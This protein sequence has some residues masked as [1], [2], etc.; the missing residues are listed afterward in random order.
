MATTRLYPGGGGAPRILERPD[1]ALDEVLAPTPASE[2]AG[3]PAG[4][5][6]EP[7]ARGGDAS[8]N[9]ADGVGLAKPEA[10]GEADRRVA[11]RTASFAW[12]AL[13]SDES[14]EL[15]RI[16]DRL[17]VHEHALG[18]AVST[19]E[20]PRIVRYADHSL[21][22]L[23]T[24]SLASASGPFAGDG[25]GPAADS[26]LAPAIVRER[27]VALVLPR[28]LVTIST[29]GFPLDAV[30]ETADAEHAISGCGVP[31][32]SWALLTTVVDAH[33]DVLESL[34][35]EADALVDAVFEPR[36]DTAAL[37]RRA[38]SLRRA[39]ASV[40][41]STLPMRELATSLER[42]S[43]STIDPVLLPYFTDVYDHTVHAADW[44]ETLS[45]TVSSI[46][47]TN[48]ALQGN[49][50]NDI[51]KRVTSWAAIIA[52]PTAITGY[53]GQNFQFLGFGTDWGAW[54]SLG[55]IALSGLV[56]YA[57]FKR[58]DWL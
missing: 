15:E 56:L 49:R 17:G 31:F 5:G 30:A 44:A 19:R 45:D 35:D 25:P 42:R 7:G 6:A 24:V 1:E 11:P 4:E 32:L 37:Q 40:R 36:P 41:H 58:R 20:R 12:I 55:A 3:G 13:G 21:L 39:I 33:I 51:M 18:V 29:P 23:S 50:M 48:V 57:L 28:V 43:P 9:G 14:E 22:V 54:M 38:F 53:F 27:C 52:V 47:E 2:S 8:P 16:A 46:M 10:E 34:D 26:A